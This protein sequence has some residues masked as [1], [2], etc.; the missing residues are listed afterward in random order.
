MK[1]IF[2]ALAILAVSF[3]AFSACDE[4][5]L[6]GEF[7]IPDAESQ[8]FFNSGVQFKAAGES[9][10]QSIRVSFVAPEAWTASAEEETKG[11]PWLTVDPSS[12][13]A[14]KAEIT[15]TAKGNTEKTPRDAT[16]TITSGSV[17]KTLPIHQ[18]AKAEEASA[19]D[20]IRLNKSTLTLVQGQT[21]KL[22]A[23][24]Q[25]GKV[26]K[27]SWS[28]SDPNI[29]K[30]DGEGNVTGNDVGKATITAVVDKLS[31]T[32][33]VT[34][35]KK[36]EEPSTGEIRLSKTTLTLHKEQT[37]KLEALDKDG[38]VLKANWST[39]NDHIAKVDDE[40]NVTGH[41]I[42]KATITAVVGKA[43][44][45]CEVTVEDEIGVQSLELVEHELTI[46]VD[47]SYTLT[48][49]VH[50]EGASLKDLRWVSAGPSVVTVDDK[51]KVT[52]IKP[53][54]AHVTVGIGDHPSEGMYDRCLV[55]VIPAD[56]VPVTA[57]TLDKT[58]L[59]LNK[60]DY[61]VVT[62][63][64]TPANFNQALNWKPQ[65]PTIVDVVLDG[66]TKAIFKAKAPGKTKVDV[67]AGTT[68]FA[69]CEVTVTATSTTVPVSGVTLD[70]TSLNLQE[71][72]GYTLTATV[73][74]D[75]ATDKTVTWSSSNESVASVVNGYVSAKKAGNATITATAGDKSATCVVT[76][77]AVEIQSIAFNP[78]SR[79][80]Y[81]GK[82]EAVYVQISPADA[83]PDVQWSSSQP[84]VVAVEDA[85]GEGYTS[86]SMKILNPLKAGT[87][88]ITA[89]AG[90]KSATL[91]VTVEDVALARIELS[92]SW[93]TLRVGD[94]QRLEAKC[95]NN[96]GS[97]ASGC[98][99]EWS[100]NNP[101]VAKVEKVNDSM[102]KI[103]A[104]SAGP[105][106][107]FASVGDVK[108]QCVVQVQGE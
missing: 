18:D 14:G 6:P 16:I 72:Q 104:V 30:V 66:P 32:C 54:S 55:T 59:T 73:S 17:K 43:S 29:A 98:V 19:D 91:S 40:G 45:T 82:K 61:E 69:S 35:E 24:G 99:V 107:I 9:G 86:S 94:T 12:G 57:V 37:E 58:S 92:Q 41:D 103:T 80:L 47:E 31:A 106:D 2:S 13:P 77:S 75:N 97:Q 49:I 5:E 89:T 3:L 10:D 48:L 100:S 7:S 20:K 101:S 74:P 78:A 62:A 108:A 52:G 88:T 21:E 63:T 51:G 96:D 93:V 64:V 27:A 60:G 90:G 85:A 87:A 28:S 33:E 70:K 23:V 65:D 50:P 11:V 84:D 95:F 34:V 38:N 105:A 67:I 102:G 83:V 79:T 44:A 25:D 76:V 22:E 53:G 36:A 68:T 39:S 8:Q 81:T 4:V 46:K 71:G 1:R 26:L 56:L 42:G 15:I